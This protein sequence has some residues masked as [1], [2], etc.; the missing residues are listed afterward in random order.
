MLLQKDQQ[1]SKYGRNSHTWLY[2]P[3]LWPW[4]WRQQTN[5]L[6]RHFG[7]WCCITIP[8]LVTEGSVA[9]DLSSRWTFTGILNLF[10]D[11]NLDHNRAI[12]SFHNTLHLMIMCHQTEFS[13]KR[14]S[15]SDKIL[16]SQILMILSLTV[17]LTLKTA[18][19]SFWKIIWLIMMHHHTTF[20]SKRFSDSENIWTNTHWHFEMFLWPWPRTQQSSFSIKHSGAW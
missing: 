15:S 18:N 8:S 12:Q 13:C 10:C 5:L 19:Q 9:E 11:L 4:T 17:I 3:S 20:G 7:P 16:K 14:I 2:E 6:A 1:F